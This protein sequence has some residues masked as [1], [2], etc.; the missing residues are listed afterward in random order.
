M[1]I[2]RNMRRLPMDEVI[3]T[4]LLEPLTACNASIKWL[5]EVRKGGLLI[6]RSRFITRKEANAWLEFMSIIRD[7]YYYVEAAQTEPRD[8]SVHKT[9]LVGT[10]T[11]GQESIYYCIE[12]LKK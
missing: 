4:H 12:C 8:C 5:A 7:E 10:H 11:V 3:T 6:D 2:A 9:P 1:A